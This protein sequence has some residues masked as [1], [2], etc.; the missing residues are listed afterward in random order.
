MGTPKFRRVLAFAVLLAPAVGSP[1]VPQGWAGTPTA[2]GGSSKA[3]GSTEKP[4]CATP[5]CPEI[6]LGASTEVARPFSNGGEGTGTVESSGDMT[7]MLDFPSPLAAGEI[8]ETAEGYLT[9]SPSTSRPGKNPTNACAKSRVHIVGP[10]PRPLCVIQNPNPCSN[11]GEPGNCPP[12]AG[13]APSTFRHPCRIRPRSLVVIA[14]STSAG[15]AEMVGAACPF[16]RAA[17]G[18]S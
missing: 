9:C 18:S 17:P 12:R 15:E 3:S 16:Q 11:Q 8:G 7:L 14:P 2:S 13:A 10:A 5:G 4:G 1:V 6:P